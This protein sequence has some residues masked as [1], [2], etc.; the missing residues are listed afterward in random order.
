MLLRQHRPASAAPRM[1]HQHAALPAADAATQLAAPP[2]SPQRERRLARPPRSRSAHA[3][4]AAPHAAASTSSAAVPSRAEP[5]RSGIRII[6]L[7]S[8][9]SEAA[10]LTSPRRMLPRIAPISVSRSPDGLEGFAGRCWCWRRTTRRA[11]AR[12]ASRPVARSRRRVRP[13]LSRTAHA[14]TTRRIR[15][16]RLSEWRRCASAMATLPCATSS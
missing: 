1:P 16:A 14:S 7:V 12:H 13:R 11:R 5:C 9:H 15:R 2:N 8:T 3:S 6:T 10:S 4:A